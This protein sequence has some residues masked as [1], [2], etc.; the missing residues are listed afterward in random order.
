MFDRFRS[1]LSGKLQGLLKL[2]PAPHREITVEESLSFETNI[3]VNRLWYRGDGWELAQAY[4]MHIGRQTSGQTSRE[5]LPSA[6][7]GASAP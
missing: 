4:F 6:M 5:K 3:A 1:F 7:R 2:F